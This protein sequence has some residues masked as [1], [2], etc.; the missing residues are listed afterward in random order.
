MVCSRETIYL[1]L[2]HRDSWATENKAKQADCDYLVVKSKKEDGELD[3]T[4][5][6]SCLTF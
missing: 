2:L 6:S 5:A 1:V 3:E 4:G